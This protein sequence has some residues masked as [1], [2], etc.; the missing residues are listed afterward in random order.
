MYTA[1]IRQI[2]ITTEA[3]PTGGP[4]VI[5]CPPFESVSSLYSDM[6]LQIPVPSLESESVLACGGIQS[7]GVIECPP[8]E[9]VSEIVP[10]AM[11]LQIPVPSLESASELI[12]TM[13]IQHEIPPF[14]STS[15][16]NIG[17]IM[18][19]RIL[20][21][22]A[23]M[24]ET[25]FIPPMIL[26]LFP[27]PA[28]ESASELIATMLIQ[29]E[30]PPFESVS[31]P[32][33]ENIMRGRIL[34]CPAFESISE[35]VASIARNV[36]LVPPFESVSS[37]CSGLQLQIPVPPFQSATWLM[38]PTIWDGAAWKAWIEANGD[39]LTR[40]YYFTLT[41]D[42]D[43]LADVVIPISSWQARRKS[44]EPTFLSVVIPGTGYKTDIEARASGTMTIDMAYIVDG[45]E[46]Y[47]E[48]I[49]RADYETMRADE[50]GR[51]QSLTLT[52]HRTESFVNKNIDLQ[53]VVYISNDN[54]DYR[55]RCVTPDMYLNP[56]DTARYDGNSITVNQIVYSISTEGQSMDVE[57]AA[58]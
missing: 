2:S 49:C 21:C 55:F 3:P 40:L 46:Q 4:T 34:E 16:L 54:G 1:V 33:V 57:E 18:R 9:S 51:S 43:G 19:G 29:H 30:I 31:S 13:L 22:P 42:A 24:S 37:L 44:G 38:V 36:I 50:G 23:F 32:N 25:E 28:L 17:N 41:G 27:C 26:S 48:T 20:E 56:G 15:S 52:G 12:A 10:P 47:R 6:Q 58:S 7:G 14:E 11:Q 8:F 35:I 39:N 53:D 5:E 45:T